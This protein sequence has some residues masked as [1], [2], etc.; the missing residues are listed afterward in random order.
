M[1]NGT[2]HLEI[3]L[4]WII[5][6]CKWWEEG[7]VMQIKGNEIVLDHI[8]VWALW[9]VL[10]PTPSTEQ[11]RDATAVKQEII[12]VTGAKRVNK[13]GKGILRVHVLSPRF[14]SPKFNPLCSRT[15][16]NTGAALNPNIISKVWC[17]FIWKKPPKTVKKNSK[18]L[19]KKSQEL[20]RAGPCVFHQAAKAVLEKSPG[21]G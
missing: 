6:L 2:L 16:Q 4:C 20:A 14:S 7:W 19:Y 10:E 13:Y 9:C 21:A 1:R 15:W 8:C 18:P 17:D 5:T 12:G 3:H 11:L